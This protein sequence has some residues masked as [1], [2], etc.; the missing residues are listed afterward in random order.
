MRSAL[1]MFACFAVVAVASAQSFEQI[2][3]IRLNDATPRSSRALALGGVADPLADDEIAANPATLASLAH[4]RFALQAA[5]SWLTVTQI[6]FADNFPISHHASLESS[7]FSQATALIPLRRGLAVAAYVAS[8]P[9]L[10]GFEPLVSSFGSEPYEPTVC[11]NPCGYLLPVANAKFDRL[12]RRAGVAV[13]WE[14]GKFAFGAGVERQQLDETIETARAVVNG[15]PTVHNENVFRTVHDHA[16]APNAGV[17]WR[18]SPRVTLAAAYNGAGSVTRTTSACNVDGFDW[19]RCASRADAIGS[20]TVNMPDAYRLAGSFTPTERWHLVAEAVRRNFSSLASD[21]FT[22]FNE[23]HRFPYRDVTELHAGA[24]YRFTR[25]SLR[26]GWWRD[27]TRYLERFV[28]PGET[29]HHY[30]IG[31][32]MTFGRTRVDLGYDGADV[33]SQRRAVAGLAFEL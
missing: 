27:P 4:P 3:F 16:Y 24:E 31:A 25:V 30:T 17:R 1:S 26:A 29:V 10:V 7:G 12:D 9:R 14:V 23:V 22:I 6:E 8:E 19:E 13:G 32:G 21:G 33:P 5:R 28:A 2:G 15:E 20:S 18:V 11:P